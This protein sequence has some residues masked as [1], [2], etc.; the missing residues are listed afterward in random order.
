M[1][2]IMVIYAC[3]GSVIMKN[4]LDKDLGER[5]QKLRL[6]ANLTQK[7]LAEAIGYKSHVSI[8]KIENG[9][10][11]LPI[12]MIPRLCSVLKCKPEE[13]LGMEEIGPKA[14]E[15]ADEYMD[16]LRRIR[17]LPPEKRAQAEGMIDI[18]MKGQE[19]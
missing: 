1:I 2:V 14:F 11:D 12:T 8:V 7:E 18:F 6:R 16:L 17:E 19:D 3:K 5:F 13:L 9:N 4:K 10:C 15:K